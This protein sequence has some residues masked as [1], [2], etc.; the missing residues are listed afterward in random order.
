MEAA[1]LFR[2]AS[3]VFQHMAQNILVPLQPLLPPDRIP[4]VTSSMANIMSKICLAEAQVYHDAIVYCLDNLWYLFYSYIM[5]LLGK[6]SE[7]IQVS[8]ISPNSPK[9]SYFAEWI[10][11]II[12]QIACIIVKMG[13]I[14][15]IISWEGVGR[16]HIG[17]RQKPRGIWGINKTDRVF[18]S[19]SCLLI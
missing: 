15:H 13:W 5:Y 2:K 17:K 18:Q 19:I 10:D 11:L 6:R 7:K 9:F 3:G 14:D 1:T 8:L 4:E 12:A 16:K